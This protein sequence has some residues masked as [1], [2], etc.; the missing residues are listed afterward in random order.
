MNYKEKI[1]KLLALS[2]SPC[3]AEAEAAL[4]K[5]HELMAEHKLTEAE[6]RQENKKIETKYTGVTFSRRRDEWA[7]SLASVIAGYFLCRP[8]FTYKTGKQTKRVGFHGYTEDAEVCG[9]IFE[10]AV[11]CLRDELE[12]VV[13]IYNGAGDMR[14]I[15]SSYAEGFIS[16]VNTALERQKEK[17]KEEYGLVLVTPPEV[18]AYAD[19]LKPYREKEFD[20]DERFWAKGYSDGRKFSPQTKLEGGAV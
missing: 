4:A 16:G 11:D 8:L 12:K 19:S 18:N 10:Y 20:V 6:C 14:I 3:Q 5:A 15:K 9:H 1:A 2:A 17:E 7:A 13:R